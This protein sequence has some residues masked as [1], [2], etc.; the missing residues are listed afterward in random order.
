MCTM[1][2]DDGCA[3]MK[4]VV[5]VLLVEDSDEDAELITRE[6]RR[7]FELELERVQ[8][9]EDMSAAL[10]GKTWDIV[11]SDYS[12]PRFSG[13]EAFAVLQSKHLDIPFII[14]SGTIGEDVAVA[15]MRLGVRDYLLKDKLARLVPAVERELREA[16]MRA[17]RRRADEA[18]RAAE[19][20]FR[21]LFDVAPDAILLT[22]A[23]GK[24]LIANAEAHRMFGHENLVGEEVDA[25]VGEDSRERHP[26]LRAG[27]FANP[28]S[29]RVRGAREIQARRKDGKM[30]PVEITLASSSVDGQPAALAI[31]RDATD[32]R[33]LEERL[34]Q[35]QKLEAIG[36]LAGGIAHDFNNLLSVILSYSSML[37]EGLK[38]GDPMREDLGEVHKAAMRA[39]DLTRQLLAFGRK[40]ILQPAPTNLNEIV[41]RMQTLLRRL[42][43]EDIEYTV[44]L[45]AQLG[46][47]LVDPSQI[48]QIIMNLIVN[49]RDAMPTGGKV[50]VETANV[51]LDAG[52]AAQHAGVTPGAYVMIAITDTGLGMDAATQARVFE[53]FFT[54]KEVGRGTG[55]GLS[56]VFG[57]VKQSGGHVWLYSEVGKGTTFKVYFP[58]S[59]KDAMS[60]TAPPPPN[61]QRGVETILL[62][63]DDDALRVLTSTILRRNGYHVLEAANG[64][65]ALLICEQHGATIHLLLTDVIMPKMSG[66][67][68]ADR[69]KIIRPQMKVLYMSGYTDNSIVHHGVLDSDVAFLQKPITPDALARKVRDV[70]D[71]NDR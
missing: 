45:A 20:R 60:T 15:T 5:R 58:R 3:I 42:I 69:L 2:G 61:T 55:L 66:R 43:G 46:T 34:R 25:L 40:Q 33:A 53:P 47:T 50:T 48:E 35:T 37:V 64:G 31:I 30:F 24:I 23:E 10:D 63:E 39:T 59:D 14:T 1:R 7:A 49:A 16:E 32:R 21:D 52:Y 41:K 11:I 19:G 4:P 51:V 17:A 67:Q 29:R 22:S 6:L 68:V 12:M 56:T 13:P 18:L 8:T 65:D 28:E 62:V 70:L 36:S 26:H 44:L 54:T 9:A 38:A 71:G 57:I 27:F